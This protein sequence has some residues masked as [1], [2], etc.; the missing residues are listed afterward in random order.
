MSTSLPRASHLGVPDEEFEQQKLAVWLDTHGL[1]WC[2]VPNGGHRHKATAG[3]MRAAGVK[4]GVP[5]VLIFDRCGDWRGVAL[6]L[7]RRKAPGVPNGRVSPEQ[8][9]WHANLAALGWLV[10]IAYGKDDA[11]QQLVSQGIGLP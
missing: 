2:H 3:K 9:G 7:K 1:V 8:K 11:V 4:S 5:D 6:E 10:L